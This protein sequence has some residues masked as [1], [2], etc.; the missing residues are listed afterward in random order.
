MKAALLFGV[1]VLA[2]QLLGQD[3]CPPVVFQTAAAVTLGAVDANSY[4]GLLRQSDGSFTAMRYTGSAPYRLLGATPNFDRAFYSC[5][6]FPPRSRGSATL[7]ALAF[8]P[9][10]T[11]ARV[12]RFAALG[13]NATQY[14]ILGTDS[15]FF[16]TGLIV[17]YANPDLTPRNQVNIEIGA[18]PSALLTG[19]FNGDQV[20]DVM[21]FLNGT[22][23]S[24]AI[25]AYVQGNADASFAAPVSNNLGGTFVGATAL[26]LNKDS[27]LDLVVT[28]TL[29]TSSTARL[30]IL[31][32]Q[33]NGSFTVNTQTIT[34]TCFTPVA[35]D[36]NRDTNP[37]VICSASDGNL[38]AFAGMGTGGFRAPATIAVGLPVGEM[39][40]ADMNGDGN[41][42]LVVT[43]RSSTG[44]VA[45]LLGNGALGFSTQ[46]RYAGQYSSASVLVTDFD[47][48]GRLDVALGSGEVNVLAFQT[49]GL[50]LGILFGRGDG[51]LQGAPGFR[52]PAFGETD[53]LVADFNGDGRPD[54]AY[55]ARNGSF[56]LYA[57]QAGGA[58]A[59]LES[60]SLLSGQGGNVVSVAVGDFNGD[61]RVDLAFVDASAGLFVA[62]NNGAGR[63]LTV[64][65]VETASNFVHLSVGD[66]NGDNRSDLIVSNNGG[67]NNTA[68]GSVAIFTNSGTGSFT[69]TATLTP[70]TKPQ[71]AYVQDLNGDNRS[72]LVV[73]LNGIP[74]TTTSPGGVAVYAG[75]P[76]GAFSNPTVLTV[77]RN[78]GDLSVADVNAD[79][80]PDLVVQTRETE[81]SSRVAVLLNNGNNSFAAPR[82]LTTEF[83]P[84]RPVLADLNGDA[85]PE[86]VVAH[87]CG[88]TYLGYYLN[89]GGA[90]F[91]S[92]SLLRSAVSPTG[93]TVADADGDGKLDLLVSD[94]D[95]GQERTM[96]LFRNAS[97][98]GALGVAVS[99][100]SFSGGRL[101]AASIFS[102][103]GAN[104]SNGLVVNEQAVPPEEL[105]GVSVTVRDVLGT[106]RQAQLFFVSPT[107]V[108]ALLPAETALGPATISVRTAAGG[109][110]SASIEVVEYAPGLFAATADGLA[111]ANLLRI[112]ES[113][114]Q[115]VEPVVE[116]NA[117]GQVVAKPIDL[118]PPTDQVFLLL[119]GT[120]IRGRGTTPNTTVTVGGATQ[121]VQYTGAQG[122]F[123]GL[124][125]VNVRLNRNLAG[126]G[127]VD[128]LLR[129]NFT[130]NSNVI[131]V[132][133]R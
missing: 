79:N 131:K 109:L 71:R 111:A 46:H 21:V 77:G 38:I 23:F 81:F 69:R 39:A 20:Q 88:D 54:L 108:N 84:R 13:A 14:A 95:T 103:F 6:G 93:V 128:V 63:F 28:T 35:G 116:L 36:F 73:V 96:F 124:D 9:P 64:T 29:T 12:V 105:G 102:V 55:L 125:Q 27:R 37:D 90:N 24:N 123:L 34:N 11:T 5:F 70:G 129:Q 118:G 110:A 99:A 68:A 130:V 67:S 48:D 17:G 87:C 10:G 49:A 83:G 91:S 53:P 82:L 126:R 2:L 15:R 57:A 41:L 101:A 115:T 30:H 121:T 59:A 47:A 65:R 127:L 62:L 98:R 1:P 60:A 4:A 112:S 8:D 78:P 104:L 33:G 72:E 132:Q 51:T 117:A 58:Y 32:N 31:L 94:G 106:D 114:V 52:I 61:S 3:A 120:G 25:A 19:D 22:A 18:N 16:R 86:I 122:Q 40:P 74:S 45:V 75:A 92:E 80:R 133:I 97:N 26:D 42:D 43:S 66:A 113:G 85:L 107:Q 100:A 76:G 119:Y 50:Q 44:V 56:H 7:P 89:L